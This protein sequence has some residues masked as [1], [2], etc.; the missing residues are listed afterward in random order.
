MTIDILL[1]RLDKMKQTGHGKW[2][3]RCPAHDDHGPSLAIRECDD[4]RVLVHC[5]ADCPTVEV[6]DAVGLDY[7]ALYPPSPFSAHAFK[8][9]RKPWNANDVL[10]ALNVQ[11]L[12]AYNICTAAADGKPLTEEDRK[13]LQDC[14][15]RFLAGLELTNG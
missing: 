2:Q 15:R 3:A 8:P 13:A 12:T 1:Q 10:H 5:F 14:T 9:V 7:S 6:L 4:G 11:L